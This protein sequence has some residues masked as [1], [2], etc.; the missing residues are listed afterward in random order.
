M[1]SASSKEGRE[2]GTPE[3]RGGKDHGAVNVYS[4]DSERDTIVEGFVNTLSTGNRIA[5][6][7]AICDAVHVTT[8]PCISNVYEKTP[9]RNTAKLVL[10]KAPRRAT[11]FGKD[12]CLVGLENHRKAGSPQLLMA[13]RETYGHI[14][15]ASDLMWMAP[16][17]V[18]TRGNIIAD[19]SSNTQETN[20]G[21]VT[22]QNIFREVSDI[23]LKGKDPESMSGPLKPRETGHLLRSPLLDPDTSD[24]RELGRVKVRLNTPPPWLMC[25]AS[26]SLQNRRPHELNHILQYPKLPSYEHPMD[27]CLEK[28]DGKMGPS[29]GPLRYGK[30]GLQGG[31][32]RKELERE[33]IL[34]AGSEEQQNPD[35]V[36]RELRQLGIV[37]RTSCGTSYDLDFDEDA[38]PHAARASRL[39]PLELEALSLKL[40]EKEKRHNEQVRKNETERQQK[41]AKFKERQK[42][43]KVRRQQLQQNPSEVESSTEAERLKL[44]ML[45]MELQ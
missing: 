2:C 24:K 36:L 32:I 29:L 43:A 34:G 11:R 25:D 19:N 45:D 39:P 26:S 1:G 7:D 38:N 22:N 23:T 44:K 41:V 31:A 17:P 21:D 30:L 40:K 35:V 37:R 12:K 15:D 4:I 8:K 5:M 14:K 27:K 28:S 3:L 13:S 6:N 33:G 42:S 20:K 16:S 10:D 9:L 18:T